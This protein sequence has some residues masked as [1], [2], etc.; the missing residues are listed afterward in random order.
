MTAKR[1]DRILLALGGVLILIS[2]YQLFFR[3]SESAGGEK[4]GTLTSA[5]SVVKTKTAL[6]LDWRDAAI[7]A[8]LTE[9]QLIYTDDASGA[10][11][12]FNEGNTLEIGENSLVK[13]RSRGDEE[14][15]D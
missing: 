11:V 1:I 12:S 7:G 10:E 3:P 13:L 5:L 14:S 2:S 6:A 15:L 4:L 8:P 9:N